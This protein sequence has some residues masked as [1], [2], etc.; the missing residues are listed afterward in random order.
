MV[1]IVSVIES[2]IYFSLIII[3]K[4]NLIETLQNSVF[5]QKLTD[6]LNQ[7]TSK[8]SFIYQKLTTSPKSDLMSH[9]NKCC[10]LM[11]DLKPTEY[12]YENKLNYSIIS[13]TDL[14]TLKGD[15]N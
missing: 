7:N 12:N 8:F 10:L 3:N 2:R 4:Q 1:Y 14:M 15:A 11:K 5:Y 9:S 13:K 6:H